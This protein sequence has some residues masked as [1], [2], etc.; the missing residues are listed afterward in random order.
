M[1]NE[2][3]ELSC[4]NCVYS[5]LLVEAG[6]LYIILNPHGDEVQRQYENTV[7]ICRE[8]PPISGTWPQVTAEDWRGRFEANSPKGNN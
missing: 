2:K 4:R 3:N 1:K 8:S 5:Q 6:D 7:M